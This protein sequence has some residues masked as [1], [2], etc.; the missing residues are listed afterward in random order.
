M[1]HKTPTLTSTSNALIKQLVQWQERAKARKKDGVFVVE[2]QREIDLALSAQFEPSMAFL[3]PE[4]IPEHNKDHQKTQRLAGVKTYLVSPNVYK[5]IAYRD[6]TEGI[7]VVFK[8]KNHSLETLDVSNQNPLILIAEAPEKPGNIGALLR[9]A[10]A[11]GVD[12]FVLANPKTDLYN[13]NIIRSSVGGIFTTKIATG[14]TEDIIRFLKARH[15]KIYS[16]ILQ[17]AIPFT[18]ADYCGPTAIVLGTEA[19]GLSESW[20]NVS[21]ANIKIPMNGT[22]DSLN[23]SVSA[24]IIIYEAIRQRSL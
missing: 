23:L 5:K 22:I 18:Q 1:D 9:T 13:P 24:G 6:S 8:S 19:D 2:G 21:E 20:R 4:I 17:E 15:I 7:V 10:D 14:S 16:A 11:A 12:A 3:C